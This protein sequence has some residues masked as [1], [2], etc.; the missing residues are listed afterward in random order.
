MNI[1]VDGAGFTE[2][3]KYGNKGDVTKIDFNEL[4]L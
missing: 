4:H 3:S 2:I 1:D